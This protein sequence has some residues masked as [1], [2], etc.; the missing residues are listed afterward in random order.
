MVTYFCLNFLLPSHTVLFNSFGTVISKLL[1]IIFVIFLDVKLEKF[2]KHRL[3]GKYIAV[4]LIIPIACIFIAY[5]I[6]FLDNEAGSIRSTLPFTLMLF[7]NCFIF[8]ICQKL[9]E[10]MEVEH[11]NAIF[12]QQLELIT[13]HTE[14]Q[15]RIFDKQKEFRHNL[16]NY[17]IGLRVCIEHNEKEKALDMLDKILAQGEPT[18]ETIV[19]TGNTLIDTLIN[20]KYS[21]AKKYGIKTAETLYSARKKCSNLQIFPP[22]YHWFYICDF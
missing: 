13:K 3:P 20:Y 11:E 8:E 12:A 2:S 14:E 1:S 21:V 17:C 7:I 6:F 15:K 10:N 4:L 5:N 9:Y 18:R 16:K 19:D 22:N